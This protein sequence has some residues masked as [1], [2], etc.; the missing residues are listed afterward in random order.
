MDAS[1]D[2]KTLAALKDEYDVQAILE[3]QLTHYRAYKP[4][5]LGVNA[6]LFTLDSVKP[7]VLWALDSLFDAGQDSVA[8]G[9]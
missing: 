7:E 8:L 6:R 9:S 1:L 2:L 3:L 5:L 4:Q